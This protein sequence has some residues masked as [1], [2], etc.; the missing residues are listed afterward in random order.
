MAEKLKTKHKIGIIGAGKIS[1]SLVPALIKSGFEIASVSS[2][3]LASARTLAKKH[4]I[5]FYTDII[6]D[7]VAV[8]DVV[9]I[10]VPDS[11]IEIVSKTISTFPGIKGKVFIHLSGVKSISSLKALRAKG[12]VVAGYHIM[13]AFPERK[14]ES[15]KG[16]YASVEASDKK[17]LKFVK[18]IASAVGTLPFEVSGDDKVLLHI[19]CVFVSNF[20]NADYYNA[21]LV[22]N[23]IKSKIPPIEKILY[24]L[25]LTNLNNIRSVGVKQSLSGPIARKDYE[26]VNRHID[27][28]SALSRKDKN[29]SDTLESYAIQTLNLMMLSGIGKNSRK[30]K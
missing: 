6:A 23:K 1:Y 10:A 30:H 4:K 14:E 2:A 13:Q 8:S 3:K 20:L 22:Y 28:L 15:I 11:A 5:K 17:T 21:L 12:A 19:M 18:Y 26:T 16:C 24:P 9:I 27:K 7:T 29:F 25:T